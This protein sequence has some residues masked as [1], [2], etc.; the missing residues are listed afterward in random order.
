MMFGENT[1][2]IGERIYRM[3]W[4]LLGVVSLSSVV[5]LGFRPLGIGMLK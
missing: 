1:P 2:L 4:Y 5:T 3:V